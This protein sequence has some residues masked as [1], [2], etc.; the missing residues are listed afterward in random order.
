MA[1]NIHSLST[2][3]KSIK[4]IAHNSAIK[5]YKKTCHNNI[6]Q[7]ELKNKFP[8]PEMLE[9]IAAALEIDSPHLFS[10]DSFTDEAVKRV[11]GRCF[12]RYKNSYSPDR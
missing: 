12:G 4:R 6:C 9:R 1:D 2:W 7:I 11:S 10:M 3:S 5:H 8:S